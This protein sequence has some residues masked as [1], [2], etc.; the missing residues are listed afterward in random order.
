MNAAIRQAT[1]TDAER[2]ADVYLASRKTFLPFAPLARSDTEVWQWVADPLMPSGGATVATIANIAPGSPFEA[3][4]LAGSLGDV[5]D[6]S[7]P[8]Q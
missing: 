3:A 2:V 6:V 1:P 8:E 7:G 4:R 5:G